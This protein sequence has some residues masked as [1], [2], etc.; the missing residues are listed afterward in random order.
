MLKA[1]WQKAWSQPSTLFL[2]VIVC[3]SQIVFA[4]ISMDGNAKE[5][6]KL[7]NKY[8]GAMDNA[9]KQQ[10]GKQY[11]QLWPTGFLGDSE[12]YFDATEE[13][14]MII[15]VIN[16]VD[17]TTMLDNHV[18]ALKN[19]LS[20]DTHYDLSRVDNAYKKLR[21]ASEQGQL[22]FGVS[23]A[24]EGM[25]IQ[26][27]VNWAFVL[28]MLYFGVNQVATETSNEMLPLLAVSKKGRKTLFRTQYMVFQ[29]SALVVWFIANVT[30]AI[31]LTYLGGWGSMDSLVQDF[32][33]NSSPYTWNAGQVMFVVLA[34]SLL[35]SQVIAN[36]I[37]CLV[38]LSKHSMVGFSIGAGVLILPLMIALY[39][40][41]V[42]IALLLPCLMQNNWMW[43]SYREF[44]IGN[45]YIKPWQIAVI[46][47][48]FVM[49][50][51]GIWRKKQES[52]L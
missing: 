44:R 29:L 20:A 10:I 34:G 2:L 25:T 6:A 43:S 30:F 16:Y 35:S 45:F 47:L 37:F 51:T 28:F 41:S 42:G 17:F 52:K 32:Q 26:T 50:M 9:W 46:E 15:N 1:E 39:K 3:V 31:T 33:L 12:E 11:E 4:G 5:H 18:I 19:S 48:I 38:R 24:A 7:Y 36:T 8:A 23:P 40:K 13:Q 14:R 21:E 22:S 27:M 49:L